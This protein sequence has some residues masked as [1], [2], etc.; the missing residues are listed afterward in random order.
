MLRFKEFYALKKK[1]ELEAA[2][3][4]HRTDVTRATDLAANLNAQE[5]RSTRAK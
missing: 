1:E 3:D 4:I 5:D 2:D